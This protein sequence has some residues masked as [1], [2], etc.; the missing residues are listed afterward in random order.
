MSLL[1]LARLVLNQKKFAEAAVIVGASN[2][3]L[4]SIGARRKPRLVSPTFSMNM[5][6]PYGT[7]IGQ[8]KRR[9]LLPVGQNTI[10]E[11]S[12]GFDHRPY[13]IWPEVYGELNGKRWDTRMQRLGDQSVVIAPPSQY[14]MGGRL[15]MMINSSRL[16]CNGWSGSR[17]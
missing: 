4:E 2:S 9:L 13:S 16:N 1:E 14:T 6:L 10:G 17:V 11:C 7:P 15:P 3:E 12:E 5:R 8:S